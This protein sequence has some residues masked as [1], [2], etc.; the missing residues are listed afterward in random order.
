[1]ARYGIGKY[2]LNLYGSKLEHPYGLVSGKLMWMVQVDWDRDGLFTGEIEPQAICSLKIVRGRGQRLRADGLGQMHPEHESFLIEI[3]DAEARFDSFNTNSPIFS[4]IG[5]PGLLLRVLVVSSSS[6]AAAQPVFVGTL[7]SAAYDAK[8]GVSS[9]SGAGLSRSLEI[10]LA[11]SLYAPCQSISNMAWDWWFV[12]DATG[13][14]P[15]NYWKGRPAGLSLRECVGIVLDRAGWPLGSS[16]G[17]EVPDPEQPD[18]FYLDGASAWETLKD[19]ADG[20]AARLCFVR[21]GRLFVMDRLDSAGLGF[22]LAAPARAQQAAGLVRESPFE[23]LRN[24]VEVKVRPHSIALFNSNCTLADYQPIWSNHGPVA[25]PSNS[26]IEIAIKYP[27]TLGKPLQGSDIRTNLDSLSEIS[28]H[29]VWSRAD[30]TGTNLGM[31]T[32]TGQ[33]EFSLI[34]EVSGRNEYGLNYV[35][36]GNNQKFCTVRLRNWSSTETAYFFNLQVQAIGIVETGQPLTKVIEDAESQSLNGERVMV[37]NSRWIQDASMAANVGQAY[38][39]ALSVRERASV[40]SVVYQWSAD[41]LY[42]N[43]LAYDLGSHVDFGP[44]AEAGSLANFGLSGRWLIVGQELQWLSPDGQDALVKLTYEKAGVVH[45]LDGN[46]SSQVG[47]AVANLTWSHTVAAGSNRLLLVSISKRAYAAAGVGSVTYGGAALTRLGSSQVNPGDYPRTEIW[48][49]IAPAVGTADVVLIL[50][51][52]ADY[53]EAA[54]MDFRNVHQSSP[55]GSLVVGTYAVGTLSVTVPAAPG[56]LVLDGI[57]YNSGTA[58]AMAGTGQTIK[59]SGSSDGAWKGSGSTK[60]GAASQVLSW[61]L[62]ANSPSSAGFG[63]A[64]KSVGS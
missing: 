48:Y 64:I 45:V 21:D 60:P 29:A 17:S 27:E 24:R 43:L 63:V 16:F 39:D 30:R 62:P 40:A 28:P 47:S 41:L 57:C 51:S 56:D 35:Q 20:F 61:S 10:G 38:L 52:S 14:F 44:S 8:T 33:G 46:V 54:S 50:A 13:P 9:L 36:A 6:K 3:Q 53:M 1:M 32:G 34:Y 58:W 2:G 25:V 22:G 31:S 18:Y 15:F 4:Q 49:L 12:W 7:L 42:A 59:W 11:A 19:L 5:A 37:V 23:T 55:L 26:S